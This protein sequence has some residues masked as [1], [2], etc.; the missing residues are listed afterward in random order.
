LD[1]HGEWAKIFIHLFICLFVSVLFIYLFVPCFNYSFIYLVIYLFTYFFVSVLFIYLFVSVVFVYRFIYSFIYFPVYLLSCLFVYCHLPERLAV[2][3]GSGSSAPVLDVPVN[4]GALHRSVPIPISP[5]L[6]AVSPP[7]DPPLLINPVLNNPPP[8]DPPLLINPVLN[9]PAPLPPL[10]ANS[11]ITPPR[12]ANLHNK[13]DGSPMKTANYNGFRMSVNYDEWM[14]SVLKLPCTNCGSIN[15]L[16]TNHKSTIEGV[17]VTAS[18]VCSACQGTTSRSNYDN[19]RLFPPRSVQQQHSIEQARAARRRHQRISRGKTAEEV[20]MLEQY[21][22]SDKLRDTKGRGILEANLRAS[23]SVLLSGQTA[24]QHQEQSQFTRSLS[25]SKRT[26]AHHAP[27]VWQAATDAAA[28]EE[29][30]FVLSHRDRNTLVVCGD[31]GWDHKRNGNH[32]ELTLTDGY[33][34][35]TYAVMKL[36]KPIYGLDKDGKP[37]LMRPGNYHKE[38]STGMEGAA[39][40]VGYFID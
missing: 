39:W 32:F 5:P 34:Q 10:R 33:S 25:I 3:E 40:M 29:K 21:E 20:A 26:L 31:G 13:H 36:S 11:I 15:S 1:G 2:A 6:R 12:P 27:H 17:T 14:S 7:I 4:A 28:E 37:K 38:D 23:T 19:K 18:A 24:T 8:I 30:R 16:F 35:K 9:N 22:T